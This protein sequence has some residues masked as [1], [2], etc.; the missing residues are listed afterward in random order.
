[1]TRVFPSMIALSTLEYRFLSCPF[2]SV[3]IRP[4]L[5]ISLE[6]R[7]QDELECPLDH[8]VANGRNGK[9]ADFGAPVLRNFLL[10]HRHGLI[11]V[12]DQF[13]LYLFQKTLHSAFFDG[14][15]RHSVT[16]RSTA[17][18]LRHLVGLLQGLHL[19]D[20]NV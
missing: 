2:R 16:T 7:L 11:R 9:N 1:M 14:S 12:M 15:K 19:A 20:M 13:V 4:R 5:K 8:P 18:A 17:I 10:P 6:D 3:S